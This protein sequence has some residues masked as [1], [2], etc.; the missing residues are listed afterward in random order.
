MNPD[1]LKKIVFT[2]YTSSDGTMLFS[3][4]AGEFSS[5]ARTAFR[6][7]AELVCLPAPLASVLCFMIEKIVPEALMRLKV[8]EGEK[9]NANQR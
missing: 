8:L 9:A 3:K 1:R 7:E 6:D 2:E 4:A 5:I